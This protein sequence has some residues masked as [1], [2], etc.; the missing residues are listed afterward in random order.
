MGQDAL[1]AGERSLSMGLRFTIFERYLS[2][3]IWAAT[4]FVL[5]GFLAMFLF[6]DLLWELDEI[7]VGGYRIQHAIVF[8]V[9]GLPSRLVELAPIAALIGT[10]WALSQS[11][12]NSEFTVFRVSGLLP[13]ASI[14]AILRVGVPMVILTAFFSELMVP[15]SEDYRVGL[16]E[17]ASS[18]QMRSGLWVRDVSSSRDAGATGGSRFINAGR[19]AS[20]R[21]LERPQIYEFDQSQR[22]VMSME[23]ESARFVGQ[24]REEYIWEL[25]GVRQIIFSEN[26]S[27][28]EQ[29]FE[30]FKMIS[31]L[32]PTTLT[33]LVVN[34]DRMSSLDLFRYVQYLRQNKQQADRYEIALWKR[35]VYPFVIWVMML[36]ALPAAFLQARAGAVGARVFAGILVGVGFHMLNSLFSHLGVLNTWPAPVM[37]LFP[38]LVALF[39]AGFFFV[40]VQYR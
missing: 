32:S 22:L 37:A 10:L 2:R 11:A 40:W 5:A 12:A 35:I 16:R 38:S 14:K 23:A 39:A 7:G 28:S 30:R 1:A 8:V 27:V 6:L 15:L 21:V 4:T 18:G 24:S 13:S 9:L 25:R 34:P 29:Q 20:E 33:A 19:F 17:G 3:G 31:Q 36:L 26:G